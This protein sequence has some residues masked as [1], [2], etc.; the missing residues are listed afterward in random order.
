MAI[1]AP[2]DFILKAYT[3]EALAR[4]GDE[5]KALRINDPDDEEGSIVNN[6]SQDGSTDYRGFF[7]FQRY[8]YRIEANEPVK[9]FHIDWDDGADNSPEKA[10]VT[11]I[12]NDKPQFVGITSHIYTQAKAFYPLLRVKSIDG[13]LSK[14]YAPHAS[15]GSSAVASGYDFSGLD[16]DI[17]LTGSSGQ[18]HDKEE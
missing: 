15:N 12:K 1:Q 18:L 6:A 14:W 3:T 5:S 2:T 11:I 13:F 9:E 8:W 4:E 7:A 17:K 16:D 10:N